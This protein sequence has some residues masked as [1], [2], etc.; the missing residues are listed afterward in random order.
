MSLFDCMDCYP[1]LCHCDST[2]TYQPK[3]GMCAACVHIYLDCSL[4]DFKSM[5]R[6]SGP[7]E[8]GAVIVKCTAFYR[9][10]AR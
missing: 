1:K 8:R 4:L 10:E 5:P 6:I 3:G 9:D 2:T 7:D